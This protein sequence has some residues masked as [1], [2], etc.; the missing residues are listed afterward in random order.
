MDVIAFIA[1]NF[2]TDFESLPREISVQDCDIVDRKFNPQSH[3][4]SRTKI[5][6]KGMNFLIPTAVRLH[7]TTT[8]P[9]Q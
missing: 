9:P 6:K 1:H 3:F 8:V 5:L 2:S 7:S 4:Y